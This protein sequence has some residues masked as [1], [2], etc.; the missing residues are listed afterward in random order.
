MRLLNCHYLTSKLYYLVLLF[1]FNIQFVS[2]QKPRI[3]ISDWAFTDLRGIKNIAYNYSYD[4]VEDL[5]LLDTVIYDQL[6]KKIP[7]S[8]L[9]YVLKYCMPEN[10]PKA[11]LAIDN[12]EI[13]KAKMYFLCSFTYQKQDYVIVEL[14]AAENQQLPPELRPANDLYFI[15]GE[16]FMY[17]GYNVGGKKQY[18]DSFIKSRDKQTEDFISFYKAAEARGMIDST[19]YFKNTIPAPPITR[20][21][22]V[23][24]LNGHLGILAIEKNT[25]NLLDQMKRNE[26][27]AA[28]QKKVDSLNVV[29][30]NEIKIFKEQ[31]QAWLDLYNQGKTSDLLEN[32]GTWKTITITSNSTKPRGENDIR[33]PAN[34]YF[35]ENNKLRFN[36]DYSKGGLN[37]IGD[38]SIY[39][40]DEDPTNF[41]WESRDLNE[42]FTQHIIPGGGDP[43]VFISTEK[44]GT[45][46]WDLSNTPLAHFIPKITEYKNEAMADQLRLQVFGPLQLVA[47]VMKTKHY[48]N[49][50]FAPANTYDLY[51]R[52]SQLQ[53]VRD[54]LR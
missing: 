36:K 18:K 8:K 46:F 40:R 49:M 43:N 45:L 38:V 32:A 41:L 54:N 22:A 4:K 44:N 21:E 25:Q 16:Y 39:V 29:I 11:F 23:A 17:D 52:I 51:E 24:K 34:L 19:L 35:I 28:R 47:I 10:R 48:Q 15:A 42:S 9:G 26:E 37:I 2:A 6:V 14:P 50:M 20:D 13:E 53:K 30:E 33:G 3:Y 12:F 5:Y 27:Q 31:N 1:C 7:S